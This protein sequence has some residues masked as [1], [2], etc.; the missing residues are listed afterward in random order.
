VTHHSPNQDMLGFKSQSQSSNPI[1]NDKWHHQ[2]KYFDLTLRTKLQQWT[3][4]CQQSDA[5]MK[6]EMGNLERKMC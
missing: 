6:K 4:M 2:S 1:D 5:K 3:V